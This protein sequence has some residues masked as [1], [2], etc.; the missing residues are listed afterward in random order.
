M[1]SSPKKSV[2]VHS[3][4]AD[5]LNFKDLIERCMPKQGCIEFQNDQSGK[6]HSWH[7]H[8]TDETI[9]MLRGQLLFY[10][11]GGE[12]ICKSGD[13]IEL[14]KGVRHGSKA[15]FGDVQY[16]ISFAKVDFAA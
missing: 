7:Q 8:D 10:W 14:P 11:D 1:I 5:L 2:V 9:I 6:E 3:A 15:I 4:A 16:L 13:V 12:V